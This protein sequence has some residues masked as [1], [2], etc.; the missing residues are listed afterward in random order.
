M[1]LLYESIIAGALITWLIYMALAIF[2]GIV[3]AINYYGGIPYV[4]LFIILISIGIISAIY[5]Y[6]NKQSK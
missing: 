4:T 3:V 1:K 6:Q 5:Y 2:A